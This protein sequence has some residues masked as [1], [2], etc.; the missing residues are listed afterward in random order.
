MSI[1]K[2][3]LYA[4]IAAAILCGL[5]SQAVAQTEILVHIFAP[6]QYPNNSAG[7]VFLK[8]NV[9]R[10]T[11]GRVTFELTSGAVAPPRQN[12]S[13][14]QDGAVDAAYLNSG[15]ERS[16][17]WLPEVARIPFETPSAEAVSVATWRT[18]EKFFK[19]ANEFEGVKL[20]SLYRYAGEQIWSKIGKAS[21]RERVVPSL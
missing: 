18:Y 8:K 16:R 11:D 14:V 20:V 10:E 7:W 19:P 1:R 9:E 21:C 15:L 5:A 17:W 3:T 4:S 12:L 6:P 2:T 13:L